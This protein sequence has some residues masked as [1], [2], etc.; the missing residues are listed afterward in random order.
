[1]NLRLGHIIHCNKLNYTW[2]MLV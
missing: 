1:M 2:Y